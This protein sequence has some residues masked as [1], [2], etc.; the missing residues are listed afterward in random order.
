[1]RILSRKRYSHI[2]RNPPVQNVIE[3][4]KLNCT[5]WRKLHCLLDSL[6]SFILNMFVLG[7]KTETSCRTTL[8]GK[9]VCALREQEGNIIHLE[10]VRSPLF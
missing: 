6:I 8:L 10:F 5:K 7:E 1:M 9:H 3:S 4:R 2:Q